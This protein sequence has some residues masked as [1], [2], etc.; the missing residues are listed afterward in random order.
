MAATS[1]APSAEPWAEP[2]PCLFGA[3]HAM[4]VLS[5]MKLGL[6]VTRS[7][8]LMASYSAGTSSLYSRPP[9]VQSTSCT[10][11]P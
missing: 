1:S 4:I 8:A 3:G 10:C 5:R 11:Q 6:S 7:A 2:V 9:L